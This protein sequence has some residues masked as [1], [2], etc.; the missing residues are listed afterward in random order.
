M[1]SNI[2]KNILDEDIVSHII[3]NSIDNFRANIFHILEE[4]SY[5]FNYS[6]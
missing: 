6:V 2:I 1:V 5:D 4:L 3:Y